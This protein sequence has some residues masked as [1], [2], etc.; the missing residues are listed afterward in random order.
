MATDMSEVYVTLRTLCGCERVVKANPY[1]KTII[2]PLWLRDQIG[3]RVFERVE[4]WAGG[5]RVDRVYV[6]VEG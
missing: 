4:T 5:R 6:E 1:A 3:R 2:L